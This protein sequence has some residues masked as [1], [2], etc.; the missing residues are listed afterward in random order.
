MFQI[1]RSLFK[2]F[3]KDWSYE[4]DED[5][6]ISFSSPKTTLQHCVLTAVCFEKTGIEY[7]NYLYH[8]AARLLGICDI[9]TV[10]ISTVNDENSL[11][12]FWVKPTRTFWFSVIY[13]SKQ[14]AK[15]RKTFRKETIKTKDAEIEKS[16]NILFFFFKKDSLRRK[17]KS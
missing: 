11:F 7:E 1:S 2:M 15:I 5:G 9:K 10:L 14:I 16:S 12:F 17:N 4:V 8:K 6:M 13:I 3:L